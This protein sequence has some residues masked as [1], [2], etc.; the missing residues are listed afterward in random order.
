V[1]DARPGVL[2]DPEGKEYPLRQALPVEVAGPDVV[3]PEGLRAG[4]ELPE[5]YHA[6]LIAWVRA[7]NPKTLPAIN[8]YLRDQGL[9]HLEVNAEQLKKLGIELRRNRGYIVVEEE[10]DPEAEF[11]AWIGETQPSNIAA[12]EAKRKELR[13][14]K[15]KVSEAE[16]SAM[17]VVKIRGRYVLGEAQAQEAQPAQEAQEAQPKAQ[18]AQPKRWRA[19]ALEP[20]RFGALKA[21]TEAIELD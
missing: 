1:A 14:K 15:V 4:K 8:A 12:I 17:G 19:G 5:K 16:L 21:T 13:F 18:P 2:V 6:D 7:N 10:E 11:K 20:K 3:V 9:K